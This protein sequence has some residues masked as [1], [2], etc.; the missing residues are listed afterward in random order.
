MGD[1]TGALRSRGSIFRTIL[2][3]MATL[4]ALWAEDAW[5]GIDRIAAVGD[6][7]GDL[8]QFTTV[9][10]SAGVIDRDGNWSGGKTHLV[11]DGDLLDR[12]PDSRKLIE[13][14]MKLEKQARAAG[15]EV[16]CL[17]GNHETMN[18]YGDLRYVSAA[19]Y[20]SYQTDDSASLRDKAY[21]QH[22]EDLTHNPQTASI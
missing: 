19:D 3:A 20:A 16:H 15:G 9:L 6:V 13:L 1:I 7:H 22:V 8:A 4:G 12:G 18:L 14:L 2:F 17:I 21:K 11:Q 10:R 5:K